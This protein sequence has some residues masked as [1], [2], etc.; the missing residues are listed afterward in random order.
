MEARLRRARAASA[1]EEESGR[2]GRTIEAATE[3]D[4][5]PMG[6]CAGLD[7][8]EPH[9]L[10]LSPACSCSGSCSMTQLSDF[11]DEGLGDLV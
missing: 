6:E 10:P 8:L 7:A 5:T 1:E 3:G 11:C 4:L 9:S 2:G